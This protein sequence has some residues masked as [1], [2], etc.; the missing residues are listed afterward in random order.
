M[1]SSSLAAQVAWTNGSARH[2]RTLSAC[3]FE[4][5]G[6]LGV[7]AP[8]REALDAPPG[9]P[10]DPVERATDVEALPVVTLHR[11]D[12]VVVALHERIGRGERGE[13]FADEPALRCRRVVPRPERRARIGQV[14]EQEAR[15]DGEARSS[16]DGAGIAWIAWYGRAPV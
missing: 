16:G 13:L 7:E 10:G 4:Q 11:L 14:R 6:R 8:H 3:S 5:A 9:R 2:E 15:A 1:A 12:D